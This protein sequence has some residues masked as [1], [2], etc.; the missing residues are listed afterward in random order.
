MT[1]MFGDAYVCHATEIDLFGDFM[2]SFL[3]LFQLMTFDNWSDIMRGF[4]NY[5]AASVEELSPEMVKQCAGHET[6]WK[7]AW[8]PFVIYVVLSGFVFFNLII[9][10]ISDSTAVLQEKRAEEKEARKREKNQ[11]IEKVDVTE[12]MDSF[13]KR[14]SDSNS[15]QAGKN[16]LEE[17]INVLEERLNEVLSILRQNPVEN[18]RSVGVDRAGEALAD[19]VRTVSTINVPGTEFYECIDESEDPKGGWLRRNLGSF[20]LRHN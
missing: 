8:V 20:A 5:K 7:R 4:M 9:A 10:V 19:S 1:N 16:G 13:S 12:D 17:Q 14:S 11:I 18:S 15:D 6:V 3:T 2:T